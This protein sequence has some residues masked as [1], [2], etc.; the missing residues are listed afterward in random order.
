MNGFKVRII[1]GELVGEKFISIVDHDISCNEED[2]KS[3]LKK[4]VG[5]TNEYIK[6]NNLN[7]EVV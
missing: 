7:S 6:N 4:V 3:T 5:L 2:L 1:L